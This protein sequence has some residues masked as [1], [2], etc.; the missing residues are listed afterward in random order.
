MEGRVG[1]PGV[2]REVTT[3]PEV[4]VTLAG[5]LPTVDERVGRMVDF[6][7]RVVRLVVEDA[8]TLGTAEELDDSTKVILTVVL[9][10]IVRDADDE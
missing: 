10:N 9:I 1:K 7:P 5:G 2:R 4:D 6:R 8:V 3:L